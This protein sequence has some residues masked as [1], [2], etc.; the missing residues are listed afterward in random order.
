MAG[1]KRLFR[2]LRRKDISSVI[3]ECGFCPRFFYV[4]EGDEKSLESI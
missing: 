1:I 4:N 3:A 2:R